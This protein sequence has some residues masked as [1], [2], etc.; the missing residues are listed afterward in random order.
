M[1]RRSPAVPLARTEGLLV[2]TIGG[3]SVIYDTESKEAHCLAPLAAAVFAAADGHTPVEEL[4]DLASAQLG[5]PVAVEEVE[6]ALARLEER[7][8]MAVVPQEISRRSLVR[9]T[10]GATAAL[11]VTPLVTS[12]VTPA[13]AQ[14]AASPSPRC[15][16][17]QCSSQGQGDVFCNVIGVPQEDSCECEDC[18]V[19][20][21]LGIPCPTP[22]D[23]DSLP[24]GT[25]GCEPGKT[26]DGL[27]VLIEGDT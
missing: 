2:E 6:L 14:V 24:P 5:R 4:V 11:A 26:L 19:L 22:V 7:G 18:S 16:R 23:C 1:A 17:D 27:C 3:E 20:T 10:A 9:R 13:F 8:L 21:N 12:I 15:P 25:G